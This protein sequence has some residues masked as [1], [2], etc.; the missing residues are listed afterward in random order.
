MSG[1]ELLQQVRT[2]DPHMPFVMLTG[3]NDMDSIVAARDQKVSSYL[4]KPFSQEQLAQHLINAKK[5][6]ALQG[7]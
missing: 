1:F 7:I 6:S 5:M 4:L 3:R 2:V